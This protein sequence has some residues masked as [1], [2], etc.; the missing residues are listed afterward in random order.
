LLDGIELITWNDPTQLPNHWSPWQ[1]SGMSQAAF[2]VMRGVDL[3][4][5]YLNAGFRVPIAAGTDKLVEDIPLGCNRTYARVK[6]P[7]NYRSWLAGVKAGNGF[8]S[9]GPILEFGADGQTPGDVAEFQGSWRVKARAR[10]RSILP[11]T[12][13]EI[14]LNGQTVGHKTV[15]IPR[16]PPVDGLYS[17]EVE[18]TVELGSSA[19][20]AARVAEHPDLKNPL[21]PRGLSVFAHSN[22]IYF[23]RDGRKVREQASIDYLQKYVQ[24]VLHWLATNPSF[25]NEED[26]RNAQRDAED[27]LR[28]YQSL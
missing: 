2:P 14:V 4:Y 21:L 5:Q 1:N 23:L 11:F 18:T 10:A 9:N 7:A 28:V 16:N 6:E 25:A 12:T 20:L 3:Y 13:L 27:A 26:R 17:L 15:P 24:G 8:V 19:W 22:P